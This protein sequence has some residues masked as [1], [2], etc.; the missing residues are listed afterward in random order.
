[1][2]T[3]KA[4]VTIAA[5]PP[6]RVPVPNTVVPF[7]NV[8]VPGG[9]PAPGATAFTVAVNF[10]AWPKTAG[11]TEEATVVAVAA[12]FTVCASAGEVLAM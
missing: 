4:E 2:P 11:F 5:T 3:A 12:L 8:T 10:T 7:L 1:M 9:V 6:L